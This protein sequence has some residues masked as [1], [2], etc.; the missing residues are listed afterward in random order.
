MVDG[1]VVLSFSVWEIA[2]AMADDPPHW[3][4]QPLGILRRRQ[5]TWA[6]AVRQ[7]GKRLKPWISAAMRLRRRLLKHPDSPSRALALWA[8]WLP[9]ARRTWRRHRAL[10]GAAGIC[11]RL[12]K[13]RLDAIAP[14]G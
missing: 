14:I 11:R 4:G 5:R 3:G 13:A 1:G 6:R 7:R 10:A 12:R 2:Q 9:I 8:I